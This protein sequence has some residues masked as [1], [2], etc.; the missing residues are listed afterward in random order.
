MAEPSSAQKEDGGGAKAKPKVARKRGEVDCDSIFLPPCV[1]KA[2]RKDP[3]HW[4]NPISS[5][6]RPPVEPPKVVNQVALASA[7]L[8]DGIWQQRLI[9]KSMRR[10]EQRAL[11]QLEALNKAGPSEEVLTTEDSALRELFGCDTESPATLAGPSTGTSV[12]QDTRALACSD[13]TLDIGEENLDAGSDD[14]PQE[15]EVLSPEEE[16]AKG[17]IWHEVYKDAL[18][19]MHLTEKKKKEKQE[20]EERKIREETLR[21]ANTAA[22]SASQRHRLSMTQ[23]RQLGHLTPVPLESS[24]SSTLAGLNDDAD[25]ILEDFVSLSRTTPEAPEEISWGNAPKIKKAEAPKLNR[26]EVRT[27]R[28][29]QREFNEAM[30]ELFA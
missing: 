17:A 9:E 6:W 4:A 5:G 3:D 14:D 24:S 7:S 30:G 20:E 13:I 2:R 12:V 29:Q 18:E 28:K 8:K 21:A 11:K 15:W 22:N 10:H 25:T 16:E 23:R 26:S 19:I 27:L 1:R